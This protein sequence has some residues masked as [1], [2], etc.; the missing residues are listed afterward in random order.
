MKDCSEFKSRFYLTLIPNGGNSDLFAW[1]T[2]AG[3][4]SLLT[5]FSGEM[6]LQMRFSDPSVKFKAAS[7]SCVRL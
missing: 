2:R 3:D 5:L 7:P 4:A 1:S 6:I